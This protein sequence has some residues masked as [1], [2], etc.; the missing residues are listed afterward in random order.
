[1]NANKFEL[2]KRSHREN[3]REGIWLAVVI[4]LGIGVVELLLMLAI[5]LFTI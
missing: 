5:K 2:L 1:M 3:I 4:G